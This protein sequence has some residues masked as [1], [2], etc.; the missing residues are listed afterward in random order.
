MVKVTSITS[1]V[2][3]KPSAY[4]VSSRCT[5][6]TAFLGVVRSCSHISLQPGQPGINAFVP[7][8]AEILR[9]FFASG[10]CEDNKIT[11]NLTSSQI[12]RTGSTYFKNVERLCR[13]HRKF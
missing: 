2:K 8:T 13:T 5:L 6:A 12:T 9:M 1:N 4:N 10:R 3:K 7:M 11:V